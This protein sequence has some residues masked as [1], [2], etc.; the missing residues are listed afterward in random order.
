M[1]MPNLGAIVSELLRLTVYVM[2]LSPLMA[3]V[4]IALMLRRIGPSGAEAISI[5]MG[6]ISLLMAL[7]LSYQVMSLGTPDGYAMI[8][9]WIDYEPSRIVMGIW[10]D[11]LTACM[12]FLVAFIAWLVQIYS[13]GYMHQ[14]PGYGRYCA[15]LNFFIGSMLVLVMSSNMLQMFFA[16]E[17]ISVASY[18]LIGFWYERKSASDAAF[19]AILINRCGDCALLIGIILWHMW[20]GSWEIMDI[21]RTKTYGIGSFECNIVVGLMMVGIMS[22]SALMPWHIW[23]PDSMEGPT[24][25]SALLHAAT[26]VA[27]GIFWGIRYSD[28]FLLAPFMG[29]LF[30]GLSATMAVI[31]GLKAGMENHIKRV[32]AY[33]TLSQLAIMA[34]ALG[35]RAYT[36]ALFHIVTHACTKALLFLAIGKI[37]YRLDHQLSLSAM[38]GLLRPM[39]FMACLVAISGAALAGMPPLSG[40]WSKEAITYILFAQDN[41]LADYCGYMICISSFLTAWYMMRLWKMVF[42]GKQISPITISWHVPTMT[43]PMFVLFIPCLC[44][45]FYTRNIMYDPKYWHL[46]MPLGLDIQLRAMWEH[47]VLSTWQDPIYV[48]ACYPILAGALWAWYGDRLY[49]VLPGVCKRGYV[50]IASQQDYAQTAY[51]KIYKIMVI[52]SQ[53]LMFLETV[54]GTRCILQ[55]VVYVFEKGMQHACGIVHATV[56]TYVRQVGIMSMVMGGL[57]CIRRYIGG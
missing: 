57:V 56:A 6:A 11:H 35:C 33:S 10:V 31:M 55:G 51:L 39:P 18:G 2:I 27:A 22:K 1:T 21:M 46:A 7:L 3:A 29:S 38:G 37:S 50:L 28:I 40:F 54:W 14:D 25:I 4:L 16:W 5:V 36:L 30:M 43:V 9:R 48:S 45:G 26:M 15:L 17:S 52:F 44:V 13:I 19:K 42:W 8:Y 23:L 24:P 12:A 41:L 20:G 34:T 47:M 32:L 53:N 49:H